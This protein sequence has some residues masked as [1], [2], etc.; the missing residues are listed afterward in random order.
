MIFTGE[1]YQNRMVFL[2]YQHE[3]MH[4]AFE[5]SENSG[6][7]S[8]MYICTLGSDDHQSGSLAPVKKWRPAR[9]RHIHRGQLEP[10]A[11]ECMH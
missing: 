11:K 4:M 8:M 3:H 10:I 7:S 2:C 1:K 6:S 5:I 9:F